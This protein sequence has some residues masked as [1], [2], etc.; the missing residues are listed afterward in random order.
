MSIKTCGIILMLDADACLENTQRQSHIP[1]F[2]GNL[3][4]RMGKK[5]N[6]DAVFE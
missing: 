2:L 4:E 6:G 1:T 3:V 5:K